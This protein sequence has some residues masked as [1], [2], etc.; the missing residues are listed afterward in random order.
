MNLL[1]AAKNTSINAR[2][3]LLD[4]A[5]L[6]ERMTLTRHIALD[7][8]YILLL[9]KG[10]AR[11]LSGDQLF[12]LQE[13]TFMFMPAEISQSLLLEPNCNGYLLLTG[14]TDMWP[15]RTGYNTII[16]NM[17]GGHAQGKLFQVREER[18]KSFTVLLDMIAEEIHAMRPYF[19]TVIE[20]HLVQLLILAER[21]CISRDL[22]HCPS[23]PSELCER[24]GQLIQENFVRYKTVKF[25]AKQLHLHPN[26][27]NKLVRVYSGWTVKDWIK[28]SVLTE[29]KA[30]LIHSTLSIK[31]IAARLGFL[32]AHHL[33]KYFK[34]ETSMNPVTFRKK[35]SAIRQLG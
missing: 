15:E 17:L 9:I 33:S 1:L 21:Q 22:R 19:S 23:D 16:S 5:I 25:Y 11:I 35:H 34:R 7:R 29:C 10:R 3:S 28:N 24:L 2:Y 8:P 20:L 32:S 13:N 31:Q 27:L 26:H 14:E 12:R 4:L 18:L 30:L 6:T